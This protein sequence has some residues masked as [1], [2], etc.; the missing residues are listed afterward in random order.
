MRE[1]NSLDPDQ[2]RRF[3]GPD[4]GP[5]SLQRSSAND[6]SRQRVSKVLQCQDQKSGTCISVVTIPAWRVLYEGMV[7]GGGAWNKRVTYILYISGI[8]WAKNGVEFEP[9]SQFPKV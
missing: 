3:V 4:L 2:A 9:Y 6:T 1:S 5:H 8:Q 7:R